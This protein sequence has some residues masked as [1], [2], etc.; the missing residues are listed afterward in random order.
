MYLC[1]EPVCL[2][3]QSHP[4]K[5]THHNMYHSDVTTFTYNGQAVPLKR[6]NGK[7]PCPCFS[8]PHY[9]FN[10]SKVRQQCDMTEHPSPQDGSQH[11]DDPYVP[12]SDAN[13]E[14]LKAH[15]G[16][17]PFILTVD[18]YMRQFP[19]DEDVPVPLSD[20]Q[21]SPEDVPMS[22]VCDEEPAVL[23]PILESL[24]DEGTT[25]IDISA[26]SQSMNKVQ[27][28]EAEGEAEELFSD[29]ESVPDTQE[30]HDIDV[31]DQVL[32]SL[33]RCNLLVDPGFRQTI[34][35]EC[36]TI[37]PYLHAHSHQKKHHFIND[38]RSLGF[39]LPRKAALLELLSSL[40][41]HEPIDIPQTSQGIPEIPGVKVIPCWQCTEDGCFV[42]YPTRKMMHAHFREHHPE[43]RT[44][45]KTRVYPSVEC[46]ATAQ[47]RNNRRFYRVI[48]Q[49]SFQCQVY[50]E[51]ERLCQSLDTVPE[52]YV[53]NKKAQQ[54]DIV[55][56]VTQ[57]HFR[58][59]GVN[60]PVARAL[61]QEPHEPQFIRLKT[62][63]R[64]HY[65]DNA[66]HLQD[67]NTL[68]KRHLAS[69]KM[70]GAEA[71]PFDRL[72][73]GSSIN[74]D[75]A[76]TAAF[77]TCLIRSINNP[78]E[79]YP[80]FFHPDTETILSHL[81]T[82]LLDS[83]AS[84]EEIKTLIH[85][86]VWSLLSQRSN[87]YIHSDSHCLFTRFL[88]LYHLVNDAGKFDRPK[89]I[90]PTISKLQW[91]FGAT[92]GREIVRHMEEEQIDCYSAYTR[93]VEQY[94]NDTS[95]CMF[96]NLRQCMSL[97][98]ALSYNEHEMPSLTATADFGVVTVYNCPVVLDD[99]FQGMHRVYETTERKLMALFR[100]CPMDDFIT[101]LDL[102]LNPHKRA[103][104]NWFAECHENQ[105]PWWWFG[106]E[107]RNS[108]KSD[109]DRLE[110]HLAQKTTFFSVVGQKMIPNHG[111]IQE[112]LSEVD[113]VV[114]GIFYLIFT[115]WG[116]GARG[117]EM[118][119]LLYANHPNQTRHFFIV[120]GVPTI[121]M[122]YN[123]TQSIQGS[124]KMIART[125]A[126]K[127]T[128]LLILLIWQVYHVCSR[129]GRLIGFENEDAQ[130][131]LCE[132]FV[133]SGRSMTSAHYSSTL[134]EYNTRT[135][136]FALS[137]QPFRQLMCALLIRFTLTS[138]NDLDDED[139]KVGHQ[140]FGHGVS[141]GQLNYN[142]DSLSSITGL[143]IDQFAQM[144]RVC[145]KW[146]K[147]AGFLHPALDETVIEEGLEFAPPQSSEIQSLVGILAKQHT[148]TLEKIETTVTS[149]EQ[150]QRV[151][152][153]NELQAQLI[154]RPDP[155]CIVPA[156]NPSLTLSPI[157]NLPIHT[158]VRKA[159]S[160]VLG[161]H[162][163]AKP[164]KFSSPQQ[165][166]L[167]QSIVSPYHVLCVLETGGGKSAA[168]FSAPYL[169][170][171]S[172][173][174]VVSPLVALNEDLF[175]RMQSYHFKSARWGED[176]INMEE[177]QLVLVG[178][179]RVGTMDFAQWVNAPALKP[180]LKRIFIDECHK[181]ITDQDYRSC[182]Q[183]FDNL[184]Q[185]GVPITF[186]SATMLPRSIPL[187]LDT[188]NITDTRLVQE[189]RKTTARPNIKYDV[190]KISSEDWV[191]PIVNFVR[192]KTETMAADERGIVYTQTIVE[193][194]QL[195][196]EIGCDFYISRIVLDP[197]INT[198]TKKEILRRWRDAEHSPWIVATLALG[199]GIDYLAVRFVV[200]LNPTKAIDFDQETGRGGRDGNPAYSTVFYYRL[201]YSFNPKK[202]SDGIDHLARNE[203]KRF[204][205]TQDCVRLA[206]EPF[207]G[208]VFSCV[209]LDAELCHN[210]ERYSEMPF[211]FSAAGYT[212]HDLSLVHPSITATTATTTATTTAAFTK[213]V[214]DE[215][216]PM[217]IEINAQRLVSHEAVVHEAV[218]KISRILGNVVDFKCADCYVLG[219]AHLSETVHKPRN[220]AFLPTYYQ[221]IQV[222]Y[223]ASTRWP[224]CH[225]CW[226]PWRE[227]CGHGRTQ[228][229]EHVDEDQCTYRI[230]DHFKDHERFILPFLVAYI[231]TAAEPGSDA[232]S[233]CYRYRD[234]IANDLQ[235]PPWKDVHQLVSWLKQEDIPDIPNCHRFL[236]SWHKLFRSLDVQS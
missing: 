157:P 220:W 196:K 120:N 148:V 49:S 217:T 235:I 166:A 53:A 216:V 128:R 185:S 203:M 66:R 174:I 221:M 74:A 21:V 229:G 207:G 89:L 175:R 100:G 107:Q 85:K 179:H 7:V 138:F 40:G 187:L 69:E 22:D 171:Q 101:R 119:H 176:P 147:K 180:R 18:D 50:E 6:S 122:R 103:Q 191:T 38:R 54:R 81:Q 226:V 188:M 37:I 99:L 200:H 45:P 35:T 236:L 15:F 28:D 44:N 78:V 189:I 155:P 52:T 137:I 102:A 105:D 110:K 27:L 56:S 48:R 96:S 202:S 170:P 64:E 165:A 13:K 79:N 92:A 146:H 193:A 11:M 145:T 5:V 33:S 135:I 197:Q 172:M 210:C 163:E 114:K 190:R 181:I 98:S 88:I 42:C 222:G 156:R 8:P 151:W 173:F 24:E 169:F 131:Y 208:E 206:F 215:K 47:L 58:L 132:M 94:M 118:Q 12:L 130:R 2:Y 57:W 164:A 224:Y 182:F 63:T 154:R 19:P 1:K 198:E 133:L 76:A 83:T 141:I 68:T 161:H 209:Q 65:H 211:E 4:R 20:E 36:L 87:E 61:V 205:E 32:V 121:V 123:K 97:L 73:G 104:P 177:T 194:E 231:F 80:F 23:V 186:L 91:C 46:Q 129:F 159:L 71:K 160:F 77:L 162:D 90:P 25:T 139:V 109:R 184:T 16:Q 225:I 31:D 144:F 113:E 134:S 67:L 168:F 30:D 223:T 149:S 26:L 55:G 219:V 108:M 227:P 143:A 60:I 214:T 51:M 204:I 112:Y 10:Q 41:A 84:D 158:N 213:Q 34:C 199:L 86:S 232:D 3:R 43:V 14:A 218:S 140:L 228:Q 70:G 153:R 192:T 142:I 117:T 75:A 93:Y 183:V 195:A 201:P 233:E 95:H 125:P 115:T 124:G 116:G 111:A 39:H 167:I 62:L 212:R 59:E 126:P 9:R 150:R 17:T 234:P 29:E 106:S 127:V 152:F 72:Q 178:A 136:G 82:R 230:H